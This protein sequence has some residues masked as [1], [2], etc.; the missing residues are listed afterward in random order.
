MTRRNPAVTSYPVHLQS[1][2]YVVFDSTEQ[3]SRTDAK[4]RLSKLERYFA[5][6]MD[7]TFDKLKYLDYY[8]KYVIKLSKVTV[9]DPNSWL[10]TV[11]APQTAIVKRRIKQHISRMDAKGYNLENSGI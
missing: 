6:P 3:K 1:K 7:T 2:N 4:D 11:P 10:D 8:E 5:R 9:T